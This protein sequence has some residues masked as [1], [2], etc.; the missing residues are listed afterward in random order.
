M[1]IGI[2]KATGTS[3]RPAM[4]GAK[5]P[6]AK[7]PKCKAFTL[8]ELPV[9]SKR[10]TRG[11][12]LVELLVV[13]GI[14]ALLIS[15]LLPALNKARRQAQIAQCESNMRQLML[16]LTNYCQDNGGRNFPYYYN[17]TGGGANSGNTAQVNWCIDILP[18]VMPTAKS[19]NLGTSSGPA[20][21]P[22]QELQASLAALGLQSSTNT[23]FLCPAANTPFPGDS[24]NPPNSV[25]PSYQ[26]LNGV[27]GGAGTF[28]NCWAAAQGTSYMNCSYQINGWMYESGFGDYTSLLGYAGNGITT[29]TANQWFWDLPSALPEGEPSSVIPAISEGAWVDGWP[30]EY[31][32]NNAGGAQ[33]ATGSNLFVASSGNQLERYMLGRH[34]GRYENIA[35]LDCHVELVPCGN[36]IQ[37]HWH[38]YWSPISTDITGWATSVQQMQST[39][40]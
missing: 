36:L 33:N 10:E 9:V 26:G 40:N 20:G 11:F 24:Y 31:N 22:E 37:Y 6:A 28:Q 27:S 21:N 34:N 16:G 25:T 32:N 7:T 8:V 39:T 4:S 12:T 13:I 14:I 23:V 30:L 1:R 29:S 5:A 2:E 17:N 38:K 3:G 19:Y 15:I 35:F 18:Y